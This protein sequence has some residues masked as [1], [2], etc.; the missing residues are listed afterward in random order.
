MNFTFKPPR[1]ISRSCAIALLCS[2]CMQ[3]VQAQNAKGAKAVEQPLP[4]LGLEHLDIADRVQ[5][6]VIS[7]EA[8]QSVNIRAHAQSNG[9]FLLGL[10]RK[11]YVM[12]PVSTSSGAVRL[13]D[14]T[15]GAV[16]LQL[17]NKSMLMDQRAGKRLADA[18]VT[19]QQFEIARALIMYPTK[20]ALD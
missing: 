6:G 19:P 2:I 3:P 16:W 18:C 17:A 14:M 10:G 1:E 5:T 4:I 8:G 7:C 11:T 15:S 9:Y 12:Q 20:S 13:E